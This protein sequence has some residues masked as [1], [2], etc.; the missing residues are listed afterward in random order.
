MAPY[1]RIP[2]QESSNDTSTND[3]SDSSSGDGGKSFM[4]A[5]GT[6]VYIALAVLAVILI[7][8]IWAGMTSRLTYPPFN[9]KKCTECKKGIK[10][11][12]KEE[13]D[14][15]KNDHHDLNDGKGWL[16]KDCQE[17][18][19]DKMLEDELKKEKQ[20]KVEK[21]KSRMTIRENENEDDQ[22]LSKQHARRSKAP[23]SR[24][25]DIDD[26]DDV[27]DSDLTDSELDSSDD[28]GI[29]KSRREVTRRSMRPP[30][31][32]TSRI[33]ET[34]KGNSR[35]SKAPPPPPLKLKKV[36][37]ETDS[38]ADDYDT[39]DSDE[40]EERIRNAKKKIQNRGSRN[41]L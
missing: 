30:P 28:E 41:K 19:E 8:F 21:R 6:V 38:S 1:L 16:C 18:L 36:K 25:V 2:R 34:V 39:S 13:K 35:K 12:D 33:R 7:Y 9:Q 24:K 31:T 29:Q 5:H 23:S 40:D 20:D 27:D 37:Y 32:Y 11:S 14:Y 4:E 26:D 17:K 15:F 3:S 22:E 10:K